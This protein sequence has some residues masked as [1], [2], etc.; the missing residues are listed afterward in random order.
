MK[1]EPNEKREI[2]A[3]IRTNQEKAIPPE[4]IS[5]PKKHNTILS[6]EKERERAEPDTIPRPS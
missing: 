3:L 1:I 4:I 6:P 5:E 2:P